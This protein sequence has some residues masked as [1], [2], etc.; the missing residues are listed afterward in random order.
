MASST[1]ESGQAT[2]RNRCETEEDDN[3]EPVVL[4]QE[5]ECYQSIIAK[6]VLENPNSSGIQ[7]CC[8]IKCGRYNEHRSF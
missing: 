4:L 6:T 8:V 2:E 1:L 3:Y 5:N 7:V